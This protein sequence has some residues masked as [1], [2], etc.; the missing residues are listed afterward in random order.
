MVEFADNLEIAMATIVEKMATCG[1]YAHIYDEGLR[2]RSATSTTTKAV[3]EDLG[4]P[5]E[6][7]FDGDLNDP[8][9]ELYAAV[10]AFLDKVQKYFNP[11]NNG[12]ALG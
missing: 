8:L 7:V 11:G 9:Q 4:G 2:V 6:K 12:I 10:R 3:D 1:F 5:L